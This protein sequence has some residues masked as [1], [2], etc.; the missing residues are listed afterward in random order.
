MKDTS[1]TPDDLMNVDATSFV[2]D[3]VPYMIFCHEWIQT[4]DATVNA[5]RLSKDLSETIGKPF[6]LF[7]ASAAPGSD[8]AQ[9][10]RKLAHGCFTDRSKDGNDLCLIWATVLPGKGHC[11]LAARSQSGKLKGPWKHRVILEKDGGHGSFLKTF[12]G[13]LLMAL[14]QPSGRGYETLKLYPIVDTRDRLRLE[15]E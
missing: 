12:D 8:S 14:H 9:E 10:K 6:A 15:L 2:E 3:G 13:R 5:V 1:H 11:I 4:T 7:P